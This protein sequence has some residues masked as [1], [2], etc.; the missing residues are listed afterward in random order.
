MSD[1]RKDVGIVTAYGY[2]VEGGYQGTEAQYTELMGSIANIAQE[3]TDA[4]TAAETAQGK[5]EDAQEAAET[6][7]GK[8][9]D[10]Q[11][12]A[13]RAQGL[14]DDAK[15]AA[16]D[17]A[18]SA[19]ESALKAEGFAVGEQNGVEVGSDSPYYHNNAKYYSEEA[20]DSATQAAASA[21][22]SAAMTGLAP[23]FD[24]T[25]AYSAGDYVLYSGTLYQFTSAHAAGAW[26]G[27][28]AVQAVMSDGVSDLKSQL[29]YNFNTIYS[30]QIVS[31]NSQVD[32]YKLTDNG[33]VTS[34]S[35]YKILKYAITAGHLYKI[36]NAYKWQYS[37]SANVGTATRVG[38]T[39]TGS[40]ESI[41]PATATYLIVSA[42]KTDTVTITEYVYDSVDKLQAD[43][44]ALSDDLNNL[45]DGKVDVKADIISQS[46]I[47]FSSGHEGEF[48]YSANYS[49]TD[50][51]DV[52]NIDALL[53]N[54]TTATSYCAFY[55]SNK[56]YV[57]R[58]N[59]PVGDPAV[60]SIPD[61]VKYFVYSNLTASF[62]S[63]IYYVV[64]M[65]DNTLSL[66]YHAADAKAVGDMFGKFEPSKPFVTSAN[67]LDMANVS[68]KGEYWV[69]GN[70]YTDTGTSGNTSKMASVK[71]PC[72][73]STTYYNALY[74]ISDGTKRAN[75]NVTYLNYFNDTDAFISY[76]A[77]PLVSV[78]GTNQGVFTTPANTAYVMIT[79]IAYENGTD[80]ERSY[81]ALIQTTPVPYNYTE[82][83]LFDLH[84][85]KNELDG[86]LNIN[87]LKGKKVV[88][89]G[90]SLF[91]LGA[92]SMND[93]SPGI[94]LWMAEK[95]N[96]TTYNVGFGGC[97]MALFSTS[98]Y[99]WGAFC[100]HA[101]A[102]AIYDEDWT[103][104]DEAISISDAASAD[105]PQKL[106][107]YFSDHLSTL[108]SIDFSE[109]D[110]V[111]IA[112]GTNDWRKSVQ[113]LPTENDTVEWQSYIGALQYSVRLLLSKYPH[114][115]IIVCAPAWRCFLD[116]EH[117]NAYINCTDDGVTNNNGKT[118]PDFVEACEQSCKNVGHIPCFMT[119]NVLGFNPQTYARFLI[120]GTHLTLN[121]K[122]RYA[123]RLVSFM[124][125]NT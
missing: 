93:A 31:A 125:S 84:V 29:D 98:Y 4:K 38:D 5:A 44:D 58:L 123:S 63:M 70:K 9:E 69:N 87:S 86:V 61:N 35:S 71:F 24:S 100:M 3:A 80:T 11:E 105:S 92:D 94:H 72:E 120:D 118:L 108:K 66:P 107:A 75:S 7:Q 59:V 45:A 67:L 88:C 103:A 77:C 14:A 6:A 111:T 18:T 1:V 117:Q 102:K 13:E 15:S 21:A 28:D 115:Q 54:N 83:K 64:P 10:A 36:T 96:C 25:K 12:A 82:Y 85:A 23:Q 55:D 110:F 104:Q 51:I 78:D 37:T 68:G 30:H 121:G 41:A 65:I 27:T 97:N 53:L 113:M 46:S 101:L 79:F 106:S 17:S 74:N 33:T 32:N 43:V 119:Y 95:A 20:G 47:S 99:T 50:Y 122:K 56:N 62:A 76:E 19:S 124:I 60:V 81:N 91:G 40:A 2:A 22:T 42:L 49:R 52:S 90:D 26:T 112:Y 57:R 89:F 16:N 109:V 73:P 116:E 48:E 34:D 8:A 114:L 39:H